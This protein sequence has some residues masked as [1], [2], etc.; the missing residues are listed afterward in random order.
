[1]NEHN[2]VS[3]NNPAKIFMS[4]VAPTVELGGLVSRSGGAT[5]YVVSNRS[6]RSHPTLIGTIEN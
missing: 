2:Q 5:Q 6:L 4:K 1:M 3:P